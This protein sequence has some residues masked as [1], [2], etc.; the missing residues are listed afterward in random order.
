MQYILTRLIPRFVIPAILF[1]TGAA[2]LIIE[3]T[4]L[5]IL[6][7]YF[8][9]TLYTVSSV[10][11]V[12]LA[13]LAAG[14]WAGGK[15]AARADASLHFFIL[16]AAGGLSIFLLQILSVAILPLFGAFFSLTM[17]PLL[18]ALFLFTLPSALFG[19]V[20]PLAVRLQHERFPYLG[21]GGAAGEIFFI[22]TA[23]S[24]AGSIATGFFL[25]PHIG[26]DRILTTAAIAMTTLGVT[27][28]L[29]RGAIKNARR[30]GA[31]A[32][33]AILLSGV[34]LATSKE[35]LRRAGIIYIQDGVYEK[36]TVAEE[37]VDS[38]MAR[39]LYQDHSKSGAVFHDSSEPVL[40][41][42]KYFALTS[43]FVPRPQRALFLGGGTYAMP[44][45]F[46]AQNPGAVVD[47]VEIEPSLFDLGK[48]YFGVRPT[49]TIQNHIRDARRFL[50]ATTT[51]YDVIAGDVF[52]SLYS[53]PAHL[54]TR[55]FFALARERLAPDGIF[56]ANIIARITRANPSLALSTLRT[57]QSVFPTSYFFAVRSSGSAAIQNIILVGTN[58]AQINFLNDPR[59]KN[60][61]D[62]IIRGLANKMIDLNRF[63]LSGYP[64]L[65]DNYAPVEYM[66]AALLD[67]GDN[68]ERMNINGN[69]V[70]AFI[71]QQLRYG[72]RHLGAEGHEKTWRALAAELAALS[73]DVATDQWE[74][75]SPVDG[76]KYAL[77]NV[78][79]RFFPDKKQ[80]V[81][82][83]AHYDTRRFAD[84]DSGN[85]SAPVAGANDG[86]SGVAVLLEVARALAYA[87]TSLPVGVDVVFFD[88]EEG[89]PGV[90]N[91]NWKP[92]GST[93]FAADIKKFYPATLPQSAV[94]V[95]MVCKKNL[96]LRPESDSVARAKDVVRQLWRIGRDRFPA[97][98]PTDI[99][100]TILDDHTPL[101][102]RGIPAALLIDFD[103]PAWHTTRDTI[104]QCSSKSLGAVGQTLLEY[105]SAQ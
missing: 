76:E 21:V 81:L 78:I 92:I 33:L 59:V 70:M 49:T 58:G 45:R 97:V 20:S 69:E 10:L 102:E 79:A 46:L 93:H 50:A 47:V 43:L 12:I 23:G 35:E 5:R 84:R 91:L 17:G 13:A 105:L 6:S 80:R 39:V 16:I 48:K 95:D 71:S 73:S 34:L 88:G 24:I 11:G 103:Y 94:I 41:Y 1:L 38:R 60:H 64:I 57:F 63:E 101:N 74:E 100:Y 56:I 68:N 32:I 36:I 55:E 83:G 40:E 15:I 27:G 3:V 14:Y 51:R 22:S 44:A 19:A 61:V 37:R 7:P 25:I 82:L 29:R 86:A 85:P 72:P 99:H 18:A 77:A 28:M 75:V 62:P 42:P 53:I 89:F 8:G 9:A 30:I 26:I 98:F 4:A 87:S 90:S 52:H 54:L 96:R 104:D 67:G 31:A 66:T 65:T 2:V